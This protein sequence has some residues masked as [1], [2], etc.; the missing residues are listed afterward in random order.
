MIWDPTTAA[1][2][3]TAGVGATIEVSLGGHHAPEI[4]G[5]PIVASAKVTALSDGKWTLTAFT[6]GVEQDVGPMCCKFTAISQAICR[7]L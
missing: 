3:H 5:E 2:A 7:C 6:V 4:C 1:A